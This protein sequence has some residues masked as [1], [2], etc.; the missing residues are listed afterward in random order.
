MNSGALE[1]G[2]PTQ[3]AAS[4]MIALKELRAG[5][6]RRLDCHCIEKISST[7]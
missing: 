3:I 2:L 5:A 1:Q 6:Y 7:G 4:G